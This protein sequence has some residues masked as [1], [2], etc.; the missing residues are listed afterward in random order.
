M[1]K[2]QFLIFTFAIIVFLPAILFSDG[3]TFEYT[4]ESIL[5]DD[6]DKGIFKVGSAEYLFEYGIE[7]IRA[8]LYEESINRFI[9]LQQ[10]Y[11]KTLVSSMS[12]IYEGIALILLSN[13]CNDTKNALK[14]LN[15]F[16]YLIKNCGDFVANPSQDLTYFYIILANRLRKKENLDYSLRSYLEYS[17]LS[18]DDNTKKLLYTEIGYL[19]YYK[20]DFY[21]AIDMFSRSNTPEAMLGLA[22]TYSSI[23][24]FDKAIEICKNYSDNNQYSKEF[25]ICLSYFKS[26]KNSNLI[27]NNNINSNKIQGN[28]RV[29]LGSFQSIE[30]ATKT[31]ENA[32]KLL[33]IE[34]MLK[35]EDNCPKLY[36]IKV[37]DFNTAKM[38]MEKLIF[39][40]NTKCFVKD[41]SY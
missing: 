17:V 26:L 36:S 1:F 23:G 20:G 32:E 6:S 3:N 8:E 37:L 18:S 19:S 40:G 13:E 29:Y 33:G 25:S 41:I 24:D 39:F 22:K 14:S 15:K 10:K 28:Y 27:N 5:N 11:P 4:Y 9:E 35:T 21:S 34:F 30:E 16:Y 12:H 38:Y 7:L 2:K 31:K